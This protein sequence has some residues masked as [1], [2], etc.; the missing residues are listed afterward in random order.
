MASLYG[1]FP[2]EG[3]SPADGKPFGLEGPPPDAFLLG[4]PLTAEPSASRPSPSVPF[5]FGQNS[6]Q[7]SGLPQRPPPAGPTVIDFA[8][9]AEQSAFQ[10]ANHQHQHPAK[11]DGPRRSLQ[12]TRTADSTTRPNGLHSSPPRAASESA[13]STRPS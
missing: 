6:G 10:Q 5:V 2:L 4:P 7:N 1:A 12:R 8:V 9:S 11:Q 13:V 3:L